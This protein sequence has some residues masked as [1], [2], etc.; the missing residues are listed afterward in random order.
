MEAPRQAP[1]TG[2]FELGR[3][4]VSAVSIIAFATPAS[5]G[6]S[7]SR[8]LV[9]DQVVVSETKTHTLF[10][11]AD[12]SVGLD[13]QLYAV[14]D[15]SGSSWVIVVNGKARVVSAKSGTIDLKISSL[16]LT[17][18]SATLAGLDAKPAYSAK[19]D[20]S[21]RLTKAMANAADVN[22]GYQASV[23]QSQ[24]SLVQAQNNAQYI[25]NTNNRDAPAIA[26]AGG[27]PMVMSPAF[28]PL[29]ANVM[30]GIR[31]TDLDQVTVSAG[32]EIEMNG[33]AAASPGYDA[34]EVTFVASSEHRLNNPYVVT[35]SQ[36]HE[37]GTKPG[38]VRKLVFAK[39]LHP[40][41]SN[42]TTVHFFE[43]G[44]PPAFE[45]QSFEVHLYDRGVEIATNVS[46][47][48]VELTRDEAFEYV[49]VEYIGAHKGET[50]PA[51]PAMGSLPADLPALLA[52]GKYGATYYVKVSKDGLAR[53][54]FLDPGCSEKT[55]DPY[56]ESA[57]KNIRFKP[58]LDKGRPVDGI[59]PL[60][61]GQLTI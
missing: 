8:P 43:E 61:L 17:D 47:K 13:R 28:G 59:A 9:M 46:S 50:L 31:T 52:E 57:V 45:L 2:K 60:K 10:M 3:F 18:L 26:A 38:L 51:L 32:S 41:D 20:P 37:K 48:R 14:N 29:N 5:E 22:A 30:T 23:S 16:K 25:A 7:D 58:G 1:S 12:I 55:G 35:I 4:L 56:L 39:A 53:G 54:I 33:G 24:A 15:V 21:T 44:F 36:L 27:F 40:I 34:M 6:A 11:G 19:N 42:P 49:M